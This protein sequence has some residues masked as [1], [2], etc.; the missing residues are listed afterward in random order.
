MSRFCATFFTS[1]NPL[2][3]FLMQT[4]LS[5]KPNQGATLFAVSLGALSPLVFNAVTL[6]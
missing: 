2:P 5:S 6:K 4:K 1:P 3:F